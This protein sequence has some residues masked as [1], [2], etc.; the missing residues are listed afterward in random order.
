M[1]QN[2]NPCSAALSEQPP[3]KEPS[4]WDSIEELKAQDLVTSKAEERR[5]THQLFS[6]PGNSLYIWAQMLRL[7]LVTDLETCGPRRPTQLQLQGENTEVDSGGEQCPQGSLQGCTVPGLGCFPKHAFCTP[8]PAGI[9]ALAV[10]S[11]LLC[12]F[13]ASQLWSPQ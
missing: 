4:S 11:R 13:R 9:S 6:L 10:S 3:A 8:R 7:V 1:F 5:L 2:Y 12:A